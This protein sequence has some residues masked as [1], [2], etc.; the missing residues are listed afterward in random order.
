MC[1]F[2]K[3]KIPCFHHFRTLAQQV[4]A[5]FW[6]RLLQRL[7][8]LT[9][10]FDSLS[11]SVLSVWRTHNGKV[12]YFDMNL[13]CLECCVLTLPDLWSPYGIRRKYFKTI[14]TCNLFD[15]VCLPD[16]TPE[17]VCPMWSIPL[18]VC[19][20]RVLTY[21]WTPSAQSSCMIFP[22]WHVI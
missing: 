12:G 21:A 13:T 15:P 7:K 3:F 4:L 18:N 14:L 1:A 10:I 20:Y 9:F 17:G 6:R 2:F 22:N 5:A 16:Y 11:F 19:R 8:T